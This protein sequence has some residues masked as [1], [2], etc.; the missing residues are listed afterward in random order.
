MSD[1]S[2][3][4]CFPLLF[5]LKKNEAADISGDEKKVIRELVAILKRESKP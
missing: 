1:S 5:L 2:L 3:K 4:H